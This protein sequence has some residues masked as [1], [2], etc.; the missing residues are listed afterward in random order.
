MNSESPDQPIQ[1]LPPPHLVLK[2][3][4]ISRLTLKP[5][6]G[7]W[8]KSLIS[9]KGCSQSEYS[10][11]V[12]LQPAHLSAYLCGNKALSLEVLNRLLSGVGYKCQLT[13]VLLPVEI[14]QTAQDVDF[15]PLEELLSP[16]DQALLN[17]E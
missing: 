13:I 8:I 10:D 15:I 7:D 5:R 6:E 17:M 14:G 16:E 9:K 2:R 1:S 4:D 12:G 3:E 11:T